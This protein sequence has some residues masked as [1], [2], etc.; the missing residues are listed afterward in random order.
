[1]ADEGRF[2]SILFGW[3]LRGVFPVCVLM[4]W[5]MPTTQAH[6]HPAICNC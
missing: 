4:S 1:M 3:S 2:G 6:F 5:P